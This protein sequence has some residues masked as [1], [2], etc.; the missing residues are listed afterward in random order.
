MTSAPRAASR[1]TAGTAGYLPLV[2]RS[3]VSECHVTVAGNS[4]HVHQVVAG[5]TL[6]GARRELEVTFDVVPADAAPL[7][8]AHLL[9]AEVDGR[10]VGYD[11][12]DGYNLPAERLEGAVASVDLYFKRSFDQA[13]NAAL[14]HRDRMHPF[15]LNYQV[16]TRAEVFRRMAAL[17]PLHV[18]VGRLGKSALGRSALLLPKSFEGAPIARED[19]RV[20]FMS[21]VYDP[22][23]EP[24]EEA[25]GEEVAAEREQLNAMRVACVRALREA[26]GSRFVGGLVP[27][28]FARARYGDCVLPERAVSRRRFLRALHA[29]DVAVATTGL[30]GSVQWKLSEYLAAGKAVVSEPLRYEVPSLSSP[31]NYLTFRTP[32]ECVRQTEALL[33]HPDRRLAM[34][35]ANRDYYDAFV[36]PDSAV[37]RTLRIATD[38]H[39]SMSVRR[40]PRKQSADVRPDHGRGRLW[41]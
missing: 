23:G 15:G 16:R 18:H 2:G 7:G 32:E 41:T 11:M 3:G 20:I 14:T 40:T 24:R 35:A 28:R 22:S 5:F 10:R 25:I 8:S 38:P 13:R 19:P 33:G 27:T 6:L 4:P 17:D 21:R 39:V 1:L 34:M 30:H 9:L 29:A 37:A 36:R 31:E 26:F 12:L